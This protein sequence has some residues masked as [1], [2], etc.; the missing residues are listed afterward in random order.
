[1]P[2][3]PVPEVVESELFSDEEEAEEE[4]LEADAVEEIPGESVE[5]H[6]TEELEMPETDTDV[7]SDMQKRMAST[8]GSIAESQVTVDTTITSIISE[9]QESVADPEE[10]AKKENQG[11]A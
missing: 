8:F 4:L 10:T 7:A 11:V 6:P 5:V 9:V 3:V 2:E 1:L